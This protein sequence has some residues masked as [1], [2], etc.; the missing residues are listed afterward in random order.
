MAANSERRAKKDRRGPGSPS[1]GGRR[2]GLR[3]LQDQEKILVEK[4]AKLRK[5]IEKLEGP[6][7]PRKR[8]RGWGSSKPEAGRKSFHREPVI[9]SGLKELPVTK[10]RFMSLADKVRDITGS[11]S[12]R[13][14]R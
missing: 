2:K 6:K 13:G 5:D 12:R 7:A 14:L 10:R 9:K 4:L 3:R 8:G 1:S 11:R